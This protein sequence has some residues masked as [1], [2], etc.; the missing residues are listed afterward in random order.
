MVIAIALAILS[1]TGAVPFTIK[2]C[3]ADDSPAVAASS[4]TVTEAV[5]PYATSVLE[6]VALIDVEVPPGCIVTPAV[7]PFQRIRAF[8]TKL[9]PVAVNIKS[10]EPAEMDVGLIELRVGVLPAE[11]LIEDHAFTRFVASIV[12][13][14]V[15]RSYPVPVRKPTE[16]PL[17]QFSVPEVQGLMLS[18][19]VMS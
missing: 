18:P 1:L 6:I 7:E 15:A 19:T 12:P 3:D 8:V 5:V 13:S 9:L 16:P 2:G 4:V 17:G 10:A 14:P 11:E